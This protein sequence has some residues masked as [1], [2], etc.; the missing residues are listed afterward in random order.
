[1]APKT[2]DGFPVKAVSDIPDFRDRYYEPVLAPLDASIAPPSSVHILNQGREGA[3]TGFGLAAVINLLNERRGY[4]VRVSA[5]ML[6]EMAKKFDKWPG[7]EY[8]GSSCRGAV[9]GWYAMGVSSE[10]LAPYR[11]GEG[12]WH[13]TVERAKDARSNTIGAYYR[14]RKNIVHMHAAMKEVGVVYAS[15]DVHSGWRRRAI[16]DGVIKRST[17]MIGGH[18]FA[19]VGYDANGFWVQNSW[20]PS[21]GKR[22]I[23]LWTY[24]DW[25]DNVRDAWVIRLALP[26][27][28]LWGRGRGRGNGAGGTTE[29]F[30]RGPRR[31]EIAGH[32]VHVDD[33]KFHDSG[34][35]WSNLTDVQETASCVAK[36]SKYDHLLIYAHGGLNSTKASAMRI[37]AMKE[38]FKD[39]RIYPFHFM[40]D[41]GL[42]EEVK[43][44]IL[45]K[46][47]STEDMV[48]GFTDW[49]DR[50]FEHATRRPGRALWREMKRGA[51]ASFEKST[52]PGS[53]TMSSFLSAMRATGAKPKKIHLVGHSTG[54]ILLAHLL[55]ALVS[56]RLK[57]RVSSVSLL[58]PA[59]THE[60][61][62]SHYSPL[63]KAAKSSFG[64]DKMNVY[65]LS[66]ELEKD[67]NVAKVYRK[68]LLYLVSNAFEEQLDAKLLGMTVFAKKISSQKRLSFIQSHG[69]NRGSRTRSTAHGGFDNDPY[70]LN[71][72][73]KTV[74]GKKP[75]RPFTSDDLDY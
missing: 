36:S 48:G 16:R 39:N 47:S 31:A 73:L 54:G 37:A 32:F 63:L 3:C 25:Q 55:Q 53:R 29:L 56:Q 58:A 42:L 5:R 24:E 11:V 71:D 57:T 59:A 10:A 68:S 66:E 34:K 64:I 46:R 23:A 17:N 75:K 52:T 20:G 67:D 4:A 22:G 27:P 50:R 18:A 14:L 15:A 43:D 38:I 60:L 40:Y 51:R 61:F 7:D 28:Q 13:L 74:L 26:T 33:G 8:S 30:S 41:T 2:I 69:A 1:M 6:Y 45:G 44:V 12:N 9:K 49:W 35:Y 72:I 65:N 19:I 62:D 21:W 70:T